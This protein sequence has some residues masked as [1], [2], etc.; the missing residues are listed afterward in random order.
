MCSIKLRYNLLLPNFHILCKLAYFLF[1]TSNFASITIIPQKNFMITDPAHRYGLD[2]LHQKPQHPLPS[3]NICSIVCE[4]PYLKLKTS[5][6]AR[7][8]SLLLPGFGKSISNPRPD[9]WAKERLNQ[10]RLTVRVKPIIVLC[11]WRIWFF[12]FDFLISWFLDSLISCD[13]SKARGIDWWSEEIWG[14]VY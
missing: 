9:Y 1:Y 7:N 14:S 5:T 13:S 2:L 3:T 11:L 8:C 4:V 6:T 10:K 12:G